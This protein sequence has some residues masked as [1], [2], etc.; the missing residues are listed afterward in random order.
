MVSDA[1]VHR[2]RVDVKVSVIGVVEEEVRE[3]LVEGRKGPPGSSPVRYCLHARSAARTSLPT[4]S[5]SCWVVSPSPC[6]TAINPSSGSYRSNQR[7]HPCPALASGRRDIGPLSPSGNGYL[8][9]AG[10]RLGGRASNSSSTIAAYRKTPPASCGQPLRRSRALGLFY[11]VSL[12][13]RPSA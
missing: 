5:V 4:R 11:L 13:R 2:G 7:G 10:S 9:S 1:L 12:A 3:G 6:A 8:S